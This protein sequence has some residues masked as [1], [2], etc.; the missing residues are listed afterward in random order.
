[1][2]AARRPPS[3]FAWRARRDRPSGALR[4]GMRVL[5]N[6]RALP[7]LLLAASALSFSCCRCRPGGRPRAS[8][9]SREGI[10][11]GGRGEPLSCCSSANLSFR[12]PSFSLRSLF[13]AGSSNQ[14]LLGLLL[15]RVARTGLA[16]DG[17]LERSVSVWARSPLPVVSLRPGSSA[18]SA[19]GGRRF[20]LPGSGRA[21]QAA[22]VAVRSGAGTGDISS[23]ASKGS[24]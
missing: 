14:R 24:L 7:R 20:V 15:R 2:P 23:C 13:D 19:P 16:L 11:R 18:R 4:F 17:D 10:L 5:S 3:I 21:E 8:G 22:A 6:G 1:V 9:D 12:A